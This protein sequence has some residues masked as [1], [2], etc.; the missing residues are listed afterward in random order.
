MRYDLIVIGSKREGSE[1]AIAA[2]KLG[3]HVAFV[4]TKFKIDAACATQDHFDPPSPRAMVAG[5][6]QFSLNLRRSRRDPRRILSPSESLIEL[7]SEVLK[8]A[9]REFAV[10]QQMMERLGVTQYRGCAAFVDPNRISV[11]LGDQVELLEGERF[12]IAC[13]SR[14]GANR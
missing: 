11:D 6:R 10:N 13:G 3:C 8:F 2:A 14:L 4:E 1:G 12:L 9:D 5:L 7:R